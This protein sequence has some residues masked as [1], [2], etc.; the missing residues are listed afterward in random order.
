MAA[1]QGPG[2]RHAMIEDH[3]AHFKRETLHSRRC[4]LCPGSRDTPGQQVLLTLGWIPELWGSACSLPGPRKCL[5]ANMG[6]TEES[7]DPALKLNLSP[8][9]PHTF[10]W[11]Q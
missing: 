3:D 9:I 10:H 8:Q 7:L 5:Y 11:V 2:W 6:T 1:R 4:P